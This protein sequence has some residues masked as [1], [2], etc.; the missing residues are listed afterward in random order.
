MLQLQIIKNQWQPV[1]EIPAG[2]IL[3]KTAHDMWYKRTDK[4]ALKVNSRFGCY[5]WITEDKVRYCGSFSKDYKRSN[6]PNFATRISKYMGSH[7]GVTNVRIHQEINQSLQQSS[8]TLAHFVFDKL[9]IGDGVVSF[10]DFS[11]DTNLIRVVEELL[12][13]TYRYHNQCDWNRT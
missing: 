2:V 7:T 4:E 3:E 13:C 9:I 12:I 5:A 8:V 10:T 11:N 1:I 6:K